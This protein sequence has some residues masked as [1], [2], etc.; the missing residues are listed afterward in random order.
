M[1]ITETLKLRHMPAEFTFNSTGKFEIKND[2]LLLPTGLVCG[3]LGSVIFHPSNKDEEIGEFYWI[4][5]SD[6]KMFVNELFGKQ[7]L[8]ER[9]MRFYSE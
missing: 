1:V 4:N 9:I 3:L 8:A 2:K 7:G 5:I 6:F